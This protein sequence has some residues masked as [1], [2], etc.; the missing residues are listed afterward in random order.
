MVKKANH[1]SYKN[2]LLPSK[3][4]I[5]TTVAKNRHVLLKWKIYV[6]LYSL[7]CDYEKVFYDYKNSKMDSQI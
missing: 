6:I 2:I 1:L 4:K 3:R 5:I 7:S